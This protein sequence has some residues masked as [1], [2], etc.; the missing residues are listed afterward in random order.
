MRQKQLF[1]TRPRSTRPPKKNFALANLE[2]ATIIAATPVRYVGLPLQWAS[3]IL[4]R[5]KFA[6]RFSKREL[7]STSQLVF[8]ITSEIRNPSGAGKPT[9][10]Q[11]LAFAQPQQSVK[12]A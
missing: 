5:T 10:D 1:P 11:E 7:I 6:P 4:D 9:V 2:A 8:A 12:S 3:L